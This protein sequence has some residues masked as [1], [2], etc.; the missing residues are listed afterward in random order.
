MRM[1]QQVVNELTEGV[2]V[3]RDDHGVG[4]G[5]RVLSNQTGIGVDAKARPRRRERVE[6]VRVQ[7]CPD[8]FELLCP[9]RW[10]EL[11]RTERGGVRHCDQCDLNVHY[12]R[13]EEAGRRH[14]RMGHCIAM[15]PPE[16]GGWRPDRM[17]MGRPR[18]PTS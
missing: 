14:A 2:L 1:D 3:C 10:A 12:C 17:L 7:N 8:P 13:T 9:K 6:E 16:G 11:T 5:A 15:L 18:R 4:C